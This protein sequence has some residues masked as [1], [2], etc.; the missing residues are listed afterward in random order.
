MKTKLVSGVFALILLTVVVSTYSTLSK[1][2]LAQVESQKVVVNGN[3]FEFTTAAT[4]RVMVAP[5]PT[6]PVQTAPISKIF[7]AGGNSFDNINNL[8]TPCVNNVLSSI[9]GI[10]WNQIVANATW[11]PRSHHTLT[12]FGGFMFVMGGANT[13][14]PGQYTEY[15]DVYVGDGTNWIQ[16]LANAPWAARM[17]HN[18]MSYNGKLFI[19]GGSALVGQWIF[20]ND[21]WS[22]VDGQNWIPL[23]NAPW[24]GRERFA[25]VVFNNKIWVMGG[26]GVL[27][28][29]PPQENLDDVWSSPDGINWIQ[30]TVNAPWGRRSGHSAVAYNGKIFV[31]GGA[32]ESTGLL[33]NDVW[34]STDGINW[35]QV[36]PNAPW[37]VRQGHTSLVFD[38]YMWVIGGF[39]YIWPNSSTVYTDAW[40]S[41]DGINWT[42][43]TNNIPNLNGDG[44][45]GV[46]MP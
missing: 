5:V 43:V 35:T 20:F 44:F 39:A 22:S 2:N 6:T 8:F 41:R 34:S 9:N 18:T 14:G 45:A 21:V 38:G 32:N 42:Q 4:P 31:I 17:S 40:K 24:Q 27:T 3:L 37:T 15:N 23:G 16:W 36:T 30:T 29:P 12:S 10:A 33:T 28:S 19:M 1:L 26:R 25:S 7:L 11:S 46:V 13:Q